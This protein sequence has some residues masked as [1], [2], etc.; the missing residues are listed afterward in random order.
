MHVVVDI[1]YEMMPITTLLDPESKWKPEDVCPPTM[2]L[3]RLKKHGS[4]VIN[5]HS[6]NN[7]KHYQFVF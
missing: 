1:Q 4:T 3:L 7:I 2:K 6:Q 5:A